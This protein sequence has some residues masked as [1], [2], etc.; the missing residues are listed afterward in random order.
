MQ[1]GARIDLARGVTPREALMLMA[2]FWLAAK[3]TVCRSGLPMASRLAR[4]LGRGADAAAVADAELRIM[5]LVSWQPL[6]GWHSA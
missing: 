1:A 6:K 3:L 2:C 5:N 4:L